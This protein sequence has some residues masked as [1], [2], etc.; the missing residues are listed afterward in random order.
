MS[1]PDKPRLK[2]NVRAGLWECNNGPLCNLGEGASP[3]DAYTM[4]TYLKR[5]YAASEIGRVKLSESIME[6]VDGRT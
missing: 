6:W 3:L 5:Y 4:H 2:Y 1:M